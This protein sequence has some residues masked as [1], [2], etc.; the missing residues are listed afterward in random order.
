MKKLLL[1]AGL[2][3]RVYTP[4]Y[5]KSGCTVYCNPLNVDKLR[6]QFPGVCRVFP[7]PYCPIAT[8]KCVW[9]WQ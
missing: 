9:F 5:F 1:W 3:R 6:G 2:L 8:T 7:D 4:L